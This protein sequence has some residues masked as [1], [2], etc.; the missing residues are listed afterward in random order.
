MAIYV[1]HDPRIRAF[2]DV[3]A[4]APLGLDPDIPAL[5]DSIA[6]QV[7]GQHLDTKLTDPWKR[8]MTQT[9]LL[10]VSFVRFVVYGLR[11]SP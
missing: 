5:Q 3:M 8:K 10:G 1:M 4:W 11:G 9:K 7:S 2:F 6:F